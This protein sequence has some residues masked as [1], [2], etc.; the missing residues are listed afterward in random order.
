MPA[1]NAWAPTSTDS[2]EQRT[3]VVQEKVRVGNRIQKTLEDANIKLSSVASDVLGVSGRAMLQALIAGETDSEKLADL[4][5]R[6][7]RGKIPQLRLALEGH[8]RDHHRF[9]LKVLWDHLLHLEE[10]EGQLDQR[11]EESMR[12]FQDELSR[13][14]EIPGLNQR[15]A[16]VLLAELGDEMSVFPSAEHLASWAGMCPGNN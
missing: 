7:L 11:I 10:L 5:R 9:L 2:S 15:T 6:Q 12:P 3:Q 4:A 16:E 1:L 8:V 13:L 14:D